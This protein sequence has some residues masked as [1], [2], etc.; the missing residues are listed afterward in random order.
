MKRKMTEALPVSKSIEKLTPSAALPY[1]ICALLSFT[2]ASG[3]ITEGA[4]PFALALTA[5]AGGFP[6][7]ASAALGGFIGLLRIGCVGSYGILIA[8]LLV[9]R[10]TIGR[11]LA[12]DAVG[13]GRGSSNSAKKSRGA[14]KSHPPA[15]KKSAS[16]Q[17]WLRKRAVPAVLLYVK[18]CAEVS[19][20]EALPVRMA[21]GAAG[22]MIGG[23]LHSR[24]YD[25]SYG[26]LIGVV[27]ASALSPVLVWLYASAESR[28]N[29]VERLVVDAGRIALAASV[30]FSL[31]GSG[32]VLFDFGVAAAFA[33]TLFASRSRGMF[34]GCLYGVVCGAAL[35]T[36]AYALLYAI[37]GALSGLL[38]RISEVL[39][40]TASCA[41]GIFWAIY[42]SGLGAMSALVPELIV[43][44]AIIA[45]VCCSG[46]LPPPAGTTYAKGSLFPSASSKGARARGGSAAS[47]LMIKADDCGRRVK[48]LSDSM[49]EIS[50]AIRRVSD[51]LATPDDGELEEICSLSFEKYCVRC[52]MRCACY[53]RDGKAVAEMQR[54]MAEG[55]REDGHVSAAAVPSSFA[56][57]CYNMG[58]IIDDISAAFAKR[59]AEAKL[60]DR[61]EVV[62][63]DYEVMADM[64]KE[65][66]QYDGGEYT[67]DDKL[68]DSL[69]AHIVQTGSSQAKAAFSKADMAVFGERVKRVVARG[70]SVGT[71]TPGAEEIRDLFSTGTGLALADPEFEVDGKEVIMKLRCRESLAVR[72]GRA[73]IAMS[74]LEAGAIF[75]GRAF[76][77]SRA[78]SGADDRATRVFDIK[79]GTRAASGFGSGYGFGKTAEENCGDVISA[80]RTD[81]GRF[82]MLICDGMGTGREASLTAGVC[83]MFLEKLLTAGASMETA[84]KMLNSMMRVRKT[85]CSA[86]V[87][88][89]EIDLMNG[90][91]RFVKSGAAPSFVLRDG[92]LFRLQSKT[93]PIG[94]V[95]ALDAEMI[96]FDVCGGDTVIMLSDGVVRS[97]EDCPW[98]YDMLCDPAT[99]DIDPGETAR[100]IIGGAVKNGARDDI[101]AGVVRIAK[102]ENQ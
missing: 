53:D 30:V 50:K 49:T 42:A 2:I 96:K 48:E 14:V 35:A 45:P 92:R 7:A 67:C 88:L 9:A 87:D 46:V 58:H 91:A 6:L 51:R 21:L 16:V 36:P 99:F 27:A 37:A 89:M 17:E 78:A 71:S 81:D 102:A 65:S 28:D 94:I 31:S 25:Y 10:M 40:V 8:A 63:S 72:C 83:V 33:A 13:R 84:L 39:A 52:G 60:Y 47:M 95:R 11:W 64:L 76:Q 57:R 80:F 86:T 43:T 18:E 20:R 93:V 82:F 34:V 3:S 98:L 38:W 26:T 5:A 29:D 79:T 100:R 24:N 62:A 68:T 55:L 90:R 54:R 22:V 41:A 59:R 69:R 32:F 85:E 73:S 66:V 74:A 101:T 15:S 4:H 12:G 77:T 44:S 56:R 1:A 23:L 61:T 70:V 19:C 97:F 75:E